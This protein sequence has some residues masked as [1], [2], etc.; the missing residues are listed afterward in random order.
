MTVIRR[1]WI[2]KWRLKQRH[3]VFW[4]SHQCLKVMGT[5]LNILE[6]FYSNSLSLELESQHSVLLPHNHLGEVNM[7]KTLQSRENTVLLIFK[8]NH[9]RY[10]D[11]RWLCFLKKSA[12]VIDWKLSWK[13]IIN[14]TPFQSQQLR[15]QWDTSMCLPCIPF[16]LVPLISHKRNFQKPAISIANLVS[17]PFSF[18]K[19]RTMWKCVLL[20]KH[21]WFCLFG[22][23][24]RKE[25]VYMQCLMVV[26]VFI[27]QA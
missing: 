20:I 5:H 9:Y 11:L 13:F 27:L 12:K 10:H 16:V 21:L 15:L 1:D 3:A 2:L 6:W 19:T 7:G 25:R 22:W 23:L 18:P 17:A 24:V 4:G 26:N 14:V 8:I